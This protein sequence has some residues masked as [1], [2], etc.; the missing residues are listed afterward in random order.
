MATGFYAT[1]LEDKAMG[2]RFNRPLRDEHRINQH[3][4]A[5]SIILS[6]ITK[7]P[8]RLAKSSY[9]SAVQVLVRALIFDP[10]SPQKALVNLHPSER[11]LPVLGSIRAEVCRL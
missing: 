1:W 4:E 6:G 11:R 9:N 2:G 7:A 3:R 10:A 8:V 5:G